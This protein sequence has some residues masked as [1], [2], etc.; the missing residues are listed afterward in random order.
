MTS[1]LVLQSSEPERQALTADLEAAG[2]HVLG[3]PERD[4]LVRD[5]SCMNPDVII[6]R[7]RNPDAALFDLCT[8]LMSTAPCPVV[9][10]TNDPDADKI[11][12]ALESGVA[13][14]VVNGYDRQRLRA[15]VA[16]TQARFRREQAM[17]TELA[18]VNHRFAER[19]LIDRAKGILMRARQLSEDEAFRVLRTASMHT[20]RRVGQVSQQVIEAARYAEAV[21]RAG[22]LRML[23][24]RLVKLYALRVQDIEPLQSAKL[25][26]ESISRMD[27]TIDDLPKKVSA[28]T[29][30]DLIEGVVEGWGALKAAVLK[31]LSPTALVEV[32]GLAEQLLKKAEQLT[33]NLESGGLVTTLSVINIAGRQR[34]LSQRLAKLSLMAGLL[35]GERAAAARE[36]AA[37][38]AETFEEAMA[39]LN[40]LPLS[41]S[42]SRALLTAAAASWTNLTEACRRGRSPESQWTIGLTSETLLTISEKLTDE[43]ERSMQVLMG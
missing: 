26:A 27:A 11:S 23:S 15:V 3:A 4:T 39:Y 37:L 10:F 43:Y 22:Q 33:L 29:F 35:G 38:V 32:D 9:L 1:A 28:S 21:N 17:R 30:G 16:V 8:R 18:N 5:A 2:V 25:M 14:Y 40:G 42:D 7:E 12:A 41:T 6:I 34:M 20:S 31:P 24:Q 19:K 13:S 36:E